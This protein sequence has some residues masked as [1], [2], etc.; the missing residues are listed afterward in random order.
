MAILNGTKVISRT[1]NYADP[2]IVGSVKGDLRGELHC[3]T[4]L[5]LIQKDDG[6][7]VIS[8]GL[9][10]PYDDFIFEKLQKM[11]GKAQWDF[12]EYYRNTSCPG[13]TK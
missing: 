9:T 12:L 11:C 7:E 10:V 5:P 3:S 2:L 13:V 8:F 4:F 6:T 1:N